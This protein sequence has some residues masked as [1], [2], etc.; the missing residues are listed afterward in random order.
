[1]TDKQQNLPPGGSRLGA[2][3]TAAIAIAVA[4]AALILHLLSGCSG[5]KEGYQV[6]HL[7]L[8][9]QTA[10]CVDPRRLPV[11]PAIPNDGQD[12]RDAIQSAASDAKVLGT[13]VCLGPHN[14]HVTARPGVGAADI[15]S[16]VLDGVSLTGAGPTTRLIA[17]GGGKRA[18][19]VNASD[20]SLIW[21][22]GKDVEVKD[23]VVD[24]TQRG[25][26]EEQTHGVESRG[27]CAS[28]GAE[29]VARDPVFSGLI[30]YDVQKQP[31][32][33][34]AACPTAPSGTQCE[35]GGEL[36]ACSQYSGTAYCEQRPGSW[37]VLGWYGGGDSI[38]L[39]GEPVTPVIGARIANVVVKSA[40]RSAI[41][42]QRGVANVTIDNLTTYLVGDQAIDFEPTGWPA[43]AD[44]HLVPSTW[45]C[46]RD[47]AICG[48]GINGLRS[49]RGP[50]GGHTVS[51]SGDGAHGVADGVT[52][53]NA[54]IRNGGVH[55]I[56]ARN[57]KILDSD[58]QSTSGNLSPGQIAAPPVLHVR[59]SAV[60]VLIR[61][62]KFTRLAGAGMGPVVSAHEQGGIAPRDLTLDNAE[63]YQH[64]T[65]TVIDVVGI[66]K[67]S[68]R[69]TEITYRG[70]PAPSAG[71]YNLAAITGK[72]SAAQKLGVVEIVGLDVDGPLA[73]AVR[74]VKPANVPSVGAVKIDWV[75]TTGLADPVTGG[76]DNTYGVFFEGAAPDFYR[77][78]AQPW[79][80]GA[81]C[82]GTCPPAQ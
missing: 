56:S 54:I 46:A 71:Q 34:S 80:V 64:A 55:V 22:C 16:I 36:R 66:R 45:P 35:Y 32:A 25:D 73:G 67:L 27:N 48:V 38:R 50:R 21:A 13:N 42:L 70:A 8:A 43:P 20:W 47:A 52:I 75:I 6:S 11:D 82:V 74:L 57:V 59:K 58:I 39:F 19:R 37:L 63:L 4:L 28:V 5:N 60:D 51:L 69:Q 68:V 10:E 26:S 53:T 30:F 14:Y 61:G 31:P 23:L 72:S 40:D 76:A 15:P 18:G 77:P 7:L 24:M 12:D 3:T 81:A 78:G 17:L 9:S 2:I 44:H 1:M 79:T 62:T 41:G 49:D 29:S 33:G 65:G